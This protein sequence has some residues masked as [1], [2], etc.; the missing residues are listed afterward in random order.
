MVPLIIGRVTKTLR[1]KI[2]L[3]QNAKGKSQWTHTRTDSHLPND[4]V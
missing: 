2:E 3:E 1:E 4:I